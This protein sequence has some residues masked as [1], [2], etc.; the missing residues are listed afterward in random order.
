MTL[1]DR[2]EEVVRDCIAAH[3]PR[4]WLHRASGA[5]AVSERAVALCRESGIGVVPGACPLM[6]LPAT[7]LPHRIH[8]WVQRLTG[9]YPR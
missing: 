5:G 2:S 1:A 3:V 8:G 9:T 6:F 4:V 7:G